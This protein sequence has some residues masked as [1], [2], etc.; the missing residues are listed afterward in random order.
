MRVYG[1]VPVDQRNPKGPL[2]WV[3]VQTTTQGFDDDVYICA[4]AQTL[5]L[6]TNESPFWGNYGLP[7]HQSIMQQ[8]M[9][10]YYILQAQRFYSSFFAS[11]IVYKE[12]KIPDPLLDNLQNVNVPAPVYRF[13]VIT[14]LGFKY[15]PIFVRGAPQ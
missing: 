7:A 15:P 12:P 10:D 4:L 11:L 2:K 9:P 1:R 14:N 3:V 5:K 6:N 8:V 13:S